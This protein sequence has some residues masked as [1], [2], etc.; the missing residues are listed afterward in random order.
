MSI[1]VNGKEEALKAGQTL[2]AFLAE[3]GIDAAAVAVEINGS[4]IRREDFSRTVV[5]Q[6]AVV[7]IL[8]FVGGG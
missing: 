5:A 4:V 3:R 1:R 8:R 7:E 6:D 2:C